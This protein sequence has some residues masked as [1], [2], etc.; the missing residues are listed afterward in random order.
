MVCGE[1]KG[2]DKGNGKSERISTQDQCNGEQGKL[3]KLPEC[4]A[5]GNQPGTSVQPTSTQAAATTLVTKA[6]AEPTPVKS[7]PAEP[8][9]VESTPTEYD[10]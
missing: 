8:T 4:G 6:Y 3:Q 2:V 9:R 10:M 1:Y 7:A 5:S